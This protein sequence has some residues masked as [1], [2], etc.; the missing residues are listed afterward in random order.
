MPALIGLLLRAIGWSLV[1]LGWKLVRGLGFAAVTF[2]GVQVLMNQAKDYAFSNL[3]AVPASWLQVLGL[4]QIDVA[5]NILFSCY[6]A[7][8]VIWGMNQ[9][10]SKTGISWR[11]K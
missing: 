3:G 7:R 11:G 6:V 10:G 9:S 1:P 8:A 5:I 4:L 2:T